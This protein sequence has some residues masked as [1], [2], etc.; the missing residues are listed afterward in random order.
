MEEGT[1]GK[2]K[3]RRVIDKRKRI[4]DKRKRVV[5]GQEVIEKDKQFVAFGAQKLSV[6][7]LEFLN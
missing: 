6:L 4:I 5:D 1:E 2:G 3:R 7:A